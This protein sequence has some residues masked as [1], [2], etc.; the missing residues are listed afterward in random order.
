M[1]DP[2]GNLHTIRNGEISRSKNFCKDFTLAV[3]EVRTDYKTEMTVLRER[4]QSAGKKVQ[5]ALPEFVTG[6]INVLGI[7]DFEPSAMRIKTTMPVQPGKHFA[8][9][10][11]L[12]EMIKAEFDDAGI[13]IPP[14]HQRVTINNS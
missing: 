1:R 10:T 9:A 7:V 2:D 6:D 11:K 8:V 4:L 13:L 5:Q 12:R 14:P 3:V